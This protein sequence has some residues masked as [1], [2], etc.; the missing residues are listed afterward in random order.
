[1]RVCKE[2]KNKERDEAMASSLSGEQKIV[3]NAALPGG[4]GAV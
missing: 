2:R 3:I 1:M 4:T